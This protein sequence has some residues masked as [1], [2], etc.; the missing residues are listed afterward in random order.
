MQLVILISVKF[1]LNLSASDM[2]LDSLS[3]M[4]KG[5]NTNLILSPW[6][7]LARTPFIANFKQTC[8]ASMIANKKWVPSN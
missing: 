6:V 3:N 8:Q 1:E 2:F 5:L 7:G 4:R